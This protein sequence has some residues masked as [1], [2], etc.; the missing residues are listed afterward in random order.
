MGYKNLLVVFALTQLPLFAAFAS[1]DVSIEKPQKSSVN[2]ELLE[3]EMN[4]FFDRFITYDHNIYSFSLEQKDT[5]FTT[6][7]PEGCV[8]DGRK[9]SVTIPFDGFYAKATGFEY[10]SEKGSTDGDPN[11]YQIGGEAILGIDMLVH[12][13]VRSLRKWI[14]KAEVGYKY[15]KEKE[16]YWDNEN[17]NKGWVYR[18][19]LEYQFNRKCGFGVM[20]EHDRSENAASPDQHLSGSKK[21]TID[22]TNAIA[23]LYCKPNEA[24]KVNFRVVK[25]IDKPNK[26]LTSLAD[27]QLSQDWPDTG[28]GI[29]ID[30]V[31]GLLK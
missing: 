9:I 26:E 12:E 24:F 10:E 29:Q 6:R 2:T 3:E 20:L 19:G 7:V 17:F 22:Y 5:C 13:S 27:P 11:M 21:K 15:T 8:L 18:L 30:F 31:P 25:M 14:A 4:S 23:N 1:S 16:Y 28:Y